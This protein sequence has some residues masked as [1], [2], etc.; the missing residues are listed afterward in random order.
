MNTLN[1]YVYRHDDYI[2]GQG[3]RQSISKRTEHTSVAWRSIITINVSELIASIV[4][5]T[6][7]RRELTKPTF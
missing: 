3:S 1:N 2:M 6:D 4:D 7:C 5:E